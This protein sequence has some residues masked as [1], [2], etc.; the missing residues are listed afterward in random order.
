MKGQSLFRFGLVGV[1]GLIVDSGV[2]TILLPFV[3]PYYGRLVSFVC[4]VGTT[5]ALNRRFTFADRPSGL[6]LIHEFARY[7]VAMLGGGA[8]NYAT[9]AGLIA[10]SPLVAR[11]PVLG[12]VAG[13]LTGM[14]VNFTLARLF[15]FARPA[16]PVHE[17][18]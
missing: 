4:A 9:Y 7:F 18:E 10:V 14:M 17:T 15:I 13:S 12:V 8:V 11:W 2:L 1:A 16:D 3:G 6:S 5:W